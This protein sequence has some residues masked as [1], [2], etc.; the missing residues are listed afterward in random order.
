MIRLVRA[1]AIALAFS[2]HK[3]FVGERNCTCR[4]DGEGDSIIE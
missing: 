3:M 1:A 2:A 4:D